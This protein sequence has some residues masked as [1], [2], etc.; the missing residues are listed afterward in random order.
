M[1][2]Q[3]PTDQRPP[4]RPLP[5]EIYMRRRVVVLVA[6][7]VLVGLIVWGLSAVARSASGSSARF[8]NPRS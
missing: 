5:P 1:T 2:Y 7:L 3:R 4:K 8:P 6:L